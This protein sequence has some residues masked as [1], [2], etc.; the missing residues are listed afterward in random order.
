ML[1][2]VLYRYAGPMHGPG[3]SFQGPGVFD[4]WFNIFAV[5]KLRT[6]MAQSFRRRAFSW[7]ARHH[8]RALRLGRRRIVANKNV[9][10]KR[11][12]VRARFFPRPHG[13]PFGR[14]GAPFQGPGVLIKS[15]T[16]VGD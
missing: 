1:A 10:L 12:P 7:T 5:L 6:P 11:G 4:E 2:G 16:C 15:S 3:V 9:D 14:F 8:K 13:A